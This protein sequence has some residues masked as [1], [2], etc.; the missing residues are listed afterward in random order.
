MRINIDADLLNA[1]WTKQTWDL[2]PYKSPEFMRLVPPSE[3][4][5]FKKLPVYKHARKNGLINDNDEWC[6]SEDD[7][8]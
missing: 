5:A 4:E 1:D 6:G 7:A 3:L 8:V 2:P